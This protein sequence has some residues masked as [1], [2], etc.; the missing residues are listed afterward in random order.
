[1]YRDKCVFSGWAGLVLGMLL[2]ACCCHPV[3]AAVSDLLDDRLSVPAAGFPG[4]VVPFEV[5]TDAEN[6]SD[7]T[8]VVIWWHGDGNDT[9]WY[10]AGKASIPAS[11]A[12]TTA[13]M[14][15]QTIEKSDVAAMQAEADIDSIHHW[16]A[17]TLSWRG[18]LIASNDGTGIYDR[19]AT[20][21][22]SD[23]VKDSLYSKAAQLFPNIEVLVNAGY[24]GGANCQIRKQY[25][26]MWS[27]WFDTTQVELLSVQL[28]GG[29]LLMPDTE[30]PDD[31][32]FPQ[33]SWSTPDYVGDGCDAG[34]DLPYGL[35]NS[36][37]TVGFTRSEC[38]TLFLSTKTLLV[39]VDDSGDYLGS[40]CQ[41]LYMGSTRLL[42]GLAFYTQWR[43][44]GFTRGQVVWHE[45]ANESH[46]NYANV[47]DDTVVQDWLWWRKAGDEAT[48]DH[49]IDDDLALASVGSLTMWNDLTGMDSTTVAYL[50]WP[51][52]TTWSNWSVVSG[53]DLTVT[54][55]DAAAW[56]T[57]DAAN[58]VKTSGPFGGSNWARDYDGTLADLVL[59]AATSDSLDMDA[60][61]GMI[62][63]MWFRTLD[64]DVVLIHN[65]SSQWPLWID[66]SGY[67]GTSIGT[68][69]DAA[70]MTTAYLVND[71]EW[72]FGYVFANASTDSV[73]I[74][75]DDLPPLIVVTSGATY[76]GAGRFT[77][78]ARAAA[79]LPKAFTGQ[80]GPVFVQHMPEG[81]PADVDLGKEWRYMHGFYDGSSTYAGLQGA[82]GTTYENGVGSAETV[83]VRAGTYTMDYWWDRGNLTLT[84]ASVDG[85]IFNGSALP[86]NGTV[87]NVTA[88]ADDLILQN[89]T[90]Q[91]S[92]TF[93]LTINSLC[94]VQNVLIRGGNVGVAIRGATSADITTLNHCTID[95][96]DGAWGYGVVIDVN[97]LAANIIENSLLT[98][99]KVGIRNNSTTG[100]T[101]TDR[102]N[103]FY[104]N[105][106]ADRNG[107]G[108]GDITTT[109]VLTIDPQYMTYGSDWRVPRR[110]AKGNDGAPR[111][112]FAGYG[113]GVASGDAWLFEYLIGG[114]R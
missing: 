61:D 76:Y 19:P 57:D 86:T 105:S 91:Y 54:R 96:V 64:S 68:W 47:L 106:V 20:I 111:G 38:Q 55:S 52:S 102:Y 2:F 11:K 101:I 71:G 110:M 41:R 25:V 3:Q 59:H 12:G 63:G 92:T 114:G 51:G 53:A 26:T 103:L 82:I 16:D 5:Y 10:L 46:A 40:Q 24:G 17:T 48:A 73:A 70:D 100:E 85:V 23:V 90:I 30:R 99:S 49:V 36:E 84:G 56:T 60:R 65:G 113:M 7:V 8:R 6:Y 108:S 107:D 79:G 33:G 50:G 13:V 14:A 80:V 75:V 28:D 15:V 43:D 44:V 4:G 97:N 67:L 74:G 88:A 18:L 81:N 112:A 94:T 72:H 87:F 21:S 29:T 93:G 31:P 9:G 34:D 69:D 89:F 83:Y 27:T 32:E 78:G 35:A 45:I 104:S 109:N 95:S 42:G 66:A 77:V 62:Y 1:M 39:Y 98:N 37:A 22:G 58:W